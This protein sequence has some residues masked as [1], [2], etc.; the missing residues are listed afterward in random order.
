MTS[1]K[2]KDITK[3]KTNMFPVAHTFNFFATNYR[4]YIFELDFVKN[5]N[6]I[7]YLEVKLGKTFVK[8]KYI[9]LKFVLFE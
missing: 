3:E 5:Q 7:A 4:I 9:F 1:H 6:Q 2:A 8:T